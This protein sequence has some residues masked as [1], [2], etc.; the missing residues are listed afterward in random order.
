MKKGARKVP[1]LILGLQVF[2]IIS[3]QPKDSNSVSNFKL[4]NGADGVDF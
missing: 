3:P 1:L 4:K 2:V